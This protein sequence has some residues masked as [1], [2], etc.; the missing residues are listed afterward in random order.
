[1]TMRNGRLTALE[2]GPVFLRKPLEIYSRA[3]NSIF[4][5]DNAVLSAVRAQE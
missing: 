4:D 1:M 2:S 5:T 3:S